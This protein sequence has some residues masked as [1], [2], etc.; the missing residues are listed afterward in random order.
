MPH[1]QYPISFLQISSSLF[2]VY[3]DTPTVLVP[4]KQTHNP[5]QLL[6]RLPKELNSNNS[7]NRGFY[8][9]HCTHQDRQT[10]FDIPIHHHETTTCPHYRTALYRR[11]THESLPWQRGVQTDAFSIL[12]SRRWLGFSKIGRI[13]AH[14]LY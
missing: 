12:P 3:L 1:F 4:S 8:Y 10:A 14:E 11:R 7:P 6:P 5:S 13:D 2:T 9:L